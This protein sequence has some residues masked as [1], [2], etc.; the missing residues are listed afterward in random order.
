LEAFFTFIRDQ[1]ALCPDRHIWFVIADL[2]G[3]KSAIGD[4]PDFGFSSYAH[5]NAFFT[6]QLY[7]HTEDKNPPFD[8]RAIDYMK[9]MKE[10]IINTDNE[11]KFGSYLGYMDPTLSNHDTINLCYGEKYEGLSQT[12]LIVDPNDVFS[13]SQNVKP[14]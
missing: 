9:G 14:S 11:K 8:D 2:Y 13:N 10:S 7:I 12:K 6:W 1:K 4:G 5:R 3:G